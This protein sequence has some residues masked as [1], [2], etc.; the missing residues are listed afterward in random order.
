MDQAKAIRRDLKE[1]EKMDSIS[2]DSV[3]VP[4]DSVDKAAATRRVKTEALKKRDVMEWLVAFQER[5][6]HALDLPN[7]EPLSKI[8]FLLVISD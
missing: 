3:Q 1:E 7:G 2:V 5:K 8:R 6:L 4:T